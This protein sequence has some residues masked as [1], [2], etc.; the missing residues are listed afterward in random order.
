MMLCLEES[1]K[2]S[3]LFHRGSYLTLAKLLVSAVVLVSAAAPSVSAQNAMSPFQDESD[4]V[5]AGGRWME[6]HSEDKMTG[7]KKVRFELVAD[8]YFKEDPDY[9]P[10]VELFCEDGK[11]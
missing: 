3:Q 1:V 4:G 2:A 7:A 8:N 9:K 6:F 11:L 10:R 5:S